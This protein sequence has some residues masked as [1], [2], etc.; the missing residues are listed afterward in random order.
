MGLAHLREVGEEK[1]SLVQ[2]VP[3]EVEEFEDK[4][5]SSTISQNFFRRFALFIL[6][7]SQGHIWIF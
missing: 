1:R 7:I 4:F 5:Q 3:V 6:G 2:C